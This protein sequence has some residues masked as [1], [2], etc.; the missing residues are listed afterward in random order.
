MRRIDIPTVTLRLPCAEGGGIPVGDGAVPENRMLQAA[1]QGVGNHR[2]YGEIHVGDPQRDLVSSGQIPLERAGSAPIGERAF[3]QSRSCWLELPPA[4][5]AL[6]ARS[7][8]VSTSSRL[9]YSLRGL[10]GFFT[11]SKNS[12]SRRSICSSSRDSSVSL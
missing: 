2:C 1:C 11:Y 4:P 9:P 10:S 7:E 12:S 6:P 8:L 5:S 3:H